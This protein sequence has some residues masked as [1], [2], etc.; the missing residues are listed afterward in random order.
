MIGKVVRRG[1]LEAYLSED[2]FTR[3]PARDLARILDPNLAAPSKTPKKLNTSEV[4]KILS[5]AVD[6]LP[7]EYQ[8]LL[9]YLRSTGQP[10]RDNMDTPHPEGA[11]ILPP[12]AMQPPEF[13]LDGR[14]YS[15][16]HSHLGNSAIQFKHPADSRVLTGFINTVWEIPLLGH[17]QTFLV[18]EIHRPLPNTILSGLPCTSLHWFKTSV[19]DARPSGNMCIIEPRHILT[20]LTIYKRPKGTYGINYREILTIC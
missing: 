4:A 7:D 9:Q 20:H 16:R 3:G 18:I 2:Q 14:I 10:W 13:T 6:L 5:T 8:N 15:C 12:L 17:M 1:R 19:V 11:L